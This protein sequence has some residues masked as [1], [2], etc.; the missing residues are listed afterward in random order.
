[1]ILLLIVMTAVVVTADAVLEPLLRPLR[2]NS[3][4]SPGLVRVISLSCR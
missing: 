1:M 4:A 2:R 3:G